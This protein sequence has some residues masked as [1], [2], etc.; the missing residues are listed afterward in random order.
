[1]ALIALFY[2]LTIRDGHIW[3]DDFALF[4]LHAKN[5]AQGTPYA[6]TAYLYNP[7]YSDI[8]PKTAPP[9]YPVLLAPV[10]RVAGLDLKAMKAE[11][12]V[13]LIAGLACVGL[14]LSYLLPLP[15]A[16][17]VVA[18]LAFNPFST[19][20]KDLILTDVPFFFFCYLVVW[21]VT[22]AEATGRPLSGLLLGILIYAAYGTRVFGMALLGALI[23]AWF[24]RR[25]IPSKTVIVAAS[26]AL[27]LTLAQ[28][29]WLPGV[30][31]YKNQLKQKDS[32]I[33]L[34]H[35]IINLTAV[36]W[37]LRNDIFAAGNSSILSWAL[38]GFLLLLGAVGFVLRARKGLTFFD[39]FF[40]FYLAGVLILPPTEDPRYLYPFLPAWLFYVCV[41]VLAVPR[42]QPRT[43]LAAFTGVMLTASC[44]SGYHASF[45]KPVPEGIADP[46]FQS[47]VRY[48]SANA[49]PGANFVFLKPRLLGLLTGHSTAAVD[50]ATDF[51]EMKQYLAQIR[52]AYVITTHDWLEDEQHWLGFTSANPG[53]LEKAFELQGFTVYRVTQ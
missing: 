9:V 25:L 41:A 31:T 4:I 2:F 38:L 50:P 32:G 35:L 43:A 53:V 48:L 46:A 47:V 14:L 5:I 42:P 36:E 24:L 12:C 17:A 21:L 28:T 39:W 49:Q 6:E 45:F 8:G 19:R 40:L 18:L 7:A 26:V 13:F 51:A 23:V 30:L 37:E 11:E 16:L 33:T 27:V 52:A 34:H 22:R 29:L 3:G 15:Y 1:M 20:I 10:Y 44:A